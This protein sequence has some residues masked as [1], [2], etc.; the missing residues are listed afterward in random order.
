MGRMAKSAK[1]GT[2]F[3]INNNKNIANL[4]LLSKNIYTRND[5]NNNLSYYTTTFRSFSISQ[6]KKNKPESTYKKLENKVLNQNSFF[7]KKIY[8]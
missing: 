5:T 4:K 3:L 2:Y 8:K 7:Q 6:S 1:R